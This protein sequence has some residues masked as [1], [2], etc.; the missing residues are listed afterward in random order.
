MADLGC[1]TGTNSLELVLEV[2]EIVNTACQKLNCRA[3]EFEVF[4]NDLPSN[5]FNTVFTSLPKFYKKLEDERGTELGQCFVYGTPGSFYGRLF[6]SKFVH[7]V[8]SL[9]SLHWLSRIP[10]ELA[11]DNGEALNKGNICIAQT[12]P[13]AVW[14]AYYKLFESDFMLFLRSRSKE[15]IFEGRMVLTFIGSTKSND[16][17]YLMYIGNILNSMASE[18]LIKRP[19]LDMFNLPFYNST[20]EE[21]RKLIE[22]EGSYTLH[23]LETFTLEWHIGCNS[24]NPN[25]C[26]KFLA[27]SIKVVTEPML[28]KEFGGAIMNELFLKFQELLVRI[29]AAGKT[30]FLNIV[31]S[32]IRK[33]SNFNA[34]A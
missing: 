31:V 6:P 19:K 20:V 15:I 2:I 17:H 10:R 12:S 26:A 22:E 3:P 25:V 30:E 9:Y 16:P 7:F 14:K 5:D 11:S 13:L 18:G 27:N 23:K 8:H 24:S 28:A 21:V 32:L 4:L 34:N 33:A 29:F 1:S